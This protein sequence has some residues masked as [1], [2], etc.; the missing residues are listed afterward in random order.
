MAHLVT[1]LGVRREEQT[2]HDLD[3]ERVSY[4]TTTREV[5]LLAIEQSGNNALF[6]L[7][8]AVD[9]SGLIEE[10][11]TQVARTCTFSVPTLVAF[12][13]F[14]ELLGAHNN[15]GLG[16]IPRLRVD[17]AVFDFADDPRFENLSAFKWTSEPHGFDDGAYGHVRRL[18]DA[19]KYLGPGT[20][21]CLFF[22]RP[23]RNYRCLKGLTKPLRDEGLADEDKRLGLKVSLRLD[24]SAWQEAFCPDFHI[25]RTIASVKGVTL[26]EQPPISEDEA[27]MWCDYGCRG[28]RP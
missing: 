22:K 3:D 17:V 21:I 27:Q 16:H 19:A 2:F 11:F 20:E 24:T 14:T 6:K 5:Q 8:N 15:F 26:L 9:L 12:R 25:C 13:N 4:V 23:W 10:L 1:T 28:F 18:V 7:C